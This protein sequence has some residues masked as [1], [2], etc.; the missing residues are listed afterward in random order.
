MLTRHALAVVLTLTTSLFAACGGGSGSSPTSSPTPVPT[1]VPAVNQKPT[2]T[3]NLSPAFG[4]DS[5]TLFSF[6]AATSDPDG[7]PV[8]VAWDF[9][10]GT[11]ASGLSATKVYGRGGTFHVT[12]TASDGRGGSN[13]TSTDVVVGSMTGTW[14]GS[15]PGYT[16]LVFSLTQSGT[17]VSGNFVEQFFGEGRTDPAAPG[18]IDA[19]G[20]VEMRF[21]LSRFSDFTFKGEMDATGRRITGGVYGSGFTGEAFVM[22]KQ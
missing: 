12:V 1:P 13:S 18:H 7:D 2:I 17:I 20:H 9:G 21:K 11:R 19:S 10:D 16:N 4:I 8:S 15:I 22:V 5:L 14:I 3:G 6:S